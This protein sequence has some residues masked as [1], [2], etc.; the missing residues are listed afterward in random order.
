MCC[1]DKHAP[2][3]EGEVAYDKSAVGLSYVGE[4]AYHALR[5]KH[6]WSHHSLWNVTSG[7]VV[8]LEPTPK[9]AFV[10]DLP[11]NHSHW[12]PEKIGQLIA[13]TEI[14]CDI[15][16]LSPPDGE[17]LTAYQHALLELHKKDK[18][19]VVRMMFGHIIGVPVNCT[20]VI[21][22][23]TEL[24]PEKETKLKLWVGA[25]RKGVSWNHSKIVAVDGQYLLTGGHNLY[26]KHYLSF[27]PVHD[28]SIQLQGRVAHDASLYANKQWSYIEFMQSSVCGYIIDKMP[29]SM[30]MMLK[31]R[32]T[33][34]EFPQGIAIFPP[35]YRQDL[36][37]RYFLPE[38]AVQSPI[39]S[40][41]R[42]GKLTRFKRRPSDDAI[43]AMLLSAKHVI[44]MALQDLGPVCIPNT[45]VP[46][47]GG[48]WPKAYL[49]ALGRVIWTR[50]VHVEIVLSNPNSLPAGLNVTHGIY[51]YGWTCA[52]VGAEII[53]TI[54]EQFRTA[55]D[56]QLRQ[57]VSDNL[58]ISYLREKRG[59]HWDDGMTMALHAK[60]FIID[61]MCCYIG[62]QNL[63]IC[64]LAEWGVV[65]DDK[66]KVQELM[67]EY[68]EPM[69]AASY[70]PDDCN[71]QDVM[72]G[73]AIDRDGENPDNM[74]EDVKN[75]V[76]VAKEKSG[77]NWVHVGATGQKMPLSP[78]KGKRKDE[79]LDTIDEKKEDEKKEDK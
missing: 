66:E 60:H 6:A 47:P 13:R 18:P 21:R 20:V 53:K 33:V 16:N 39:I 10:Q 8:S 51:G 57:R 78:E 5:L 59:Q 79:S 55:N 25:W 28:V 52:D 35:Y 37:P 68:W 46:V 58:R 76:E 17:F 73:L 14:W 34:S 72:D 75:K 27:D 54:K 71:V 12:F 19:I 49:R 56:A 23:L 74:S 44:H 30:H 65:I 32:V 1:C 69:W 9:Q 45:K 40:M 64:D 38:S 22:Q 4:A 70:S 11:E 77:R 50:D 62:S 41:G 15:L 26:D 42:Y 67:A 7:V 61:D 3:S 36:I 2:G 63:Y 24:I 31:S 48:T 29:D 43:V